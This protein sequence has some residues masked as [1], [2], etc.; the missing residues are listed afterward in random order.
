M[1]GGTGESVARREDREDREVNDSGGTSLKGAATPRIDAPPDTIAERR[2]ILR[3][4]ELSR[5]YLSP[6]KVVMACHFL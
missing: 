2:I 1:L 6:R 5:I 3:P 4:T